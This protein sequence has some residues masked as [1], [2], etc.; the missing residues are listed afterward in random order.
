MDDKG[1]KLSHD[2]LIEFRL[3]NIEKQLDELK[4]LLIK[5][6]VQEE[7]VLTLESKVQVLETKVQALETKPDKKDAEKWRYIV[8]YLFKA[9]VAFVALYLLSKVGIK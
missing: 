7:K 4:A 5:V 8:D 3:I 9:V 1:P 2:E 6:P